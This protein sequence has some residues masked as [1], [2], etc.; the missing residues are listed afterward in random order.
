MERFTRIERDAA[1]GGAV[2]AEIVAPDNSRQARTTFV[3]D[4]FG[5]PVERIGGDGVRHR[6]GYT[7]AGEIAWL[8]SLRATAEPLS[9]SVRYDPDLADPALISLVRFERDRLGRLVAEREA[10]FEDAPGGRRLLGQ[11]GWRVTTFTRDEAAGRLEIVD[12]AGGV[13][14]IEQDLLGRESRRIL[15]DRLTIL[16]NQWSGDGLA[17]VATI[18]PSVF[19]GG[20]AE[21]RLRFTP[22]GALAA[23]EDASRVLLE[24]GYDRMGRLETERTRDRTM[25]YRYDQ[26][27]RMVEAVRETAAGPSPYLRVFHNRLGAPR[28]RIDGDGREVQWEYDHANRPFRLQYPDGT[29]LTTYYDVGSN[30]PERTTD[31][32]AES[33]ELPL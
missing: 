18:A 15:R 20:S 25:R 9:A 26:F 6:A 22:F 24:A 21:R 4:G 5:R 23:V 3:Y 28:R 2:R 29:A 31:R 19:A 14:T 7:R 10:W 1:R 27:G 13:T 32:S 17:M 30:R 11:N 16:T 8:A 12:T 33:E